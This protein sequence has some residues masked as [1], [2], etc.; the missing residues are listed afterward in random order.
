MQIYTFRYMRD[1]Q[2]IDEA[3]FQVNSLDEAWRRATQK[4][5][6]KK[7]EKD[8]GYVKVELIKAEVA[9]K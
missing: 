9:R 2:V 7:N 3:V 8:K 5:E 4:L 1:Y 6:S